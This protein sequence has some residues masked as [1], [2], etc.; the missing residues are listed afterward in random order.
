MPQAAFADTTWIPI[1]P[2]TDA[3]F[4]HALIYVGLHENLVDMPW[5]RRWTNAAYLITGEGPDM[6]P[7]T[8][9]DLR[10]GGR[11]NYYAVVDESGEVRFQGVKKVDGKAVGFDEDP[12]AKLN[13]EFEGT[14][15]GV[16]GKIA[17]RTVWKAFRA[18]ND[19]YSPEAASKITGIP[20]ETL[21]KTAREFFIAKGVCDDGWYSSRNANDVEAFAMMNVINLFTGAFD[22]AGG[23]IL[24]VGAATAVRGSHRKARTTRA[25]RALNGRRNLGNPW[26]SS[27]FP[28]ASAR[29]GR[30]STR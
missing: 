9:A 2:G 27:S 13:L 12:N 17:A 3:A 7:V 14:L 8:E 16:N 10:T 20:A 28:K 18:V 5:V 24:T 4:L 29:S 30:R 26:T 11:P 6:K 22:H 21:V 23:C 1:K 19:K 25:R 15:D